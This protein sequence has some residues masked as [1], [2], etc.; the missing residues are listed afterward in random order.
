ML[1]DEILNQ[2]YTLIGLSFCLFDGFINIILTDFE[3]LQ[4]QQQQLGKHSRYFVHLLFSVFYEQN[5]N[6]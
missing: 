3:S 4:V 5:L 1:W 2:K 6:V